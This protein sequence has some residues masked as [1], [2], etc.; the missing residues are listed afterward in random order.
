VSTDG[1][2]TWESENLELPGYPKSR[3]SYGVAQALQERSGTA[4]EFGKVSFLQE[5]VD[6]QTQKAFV[7][8][9]NF[10]LASAIAARSGLPQRETR[11]NRI[12]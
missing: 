4:A 12:R 8:E 10:A 1:G 7:V 5:L 9:V 3:F 6:R 11:R 2:E